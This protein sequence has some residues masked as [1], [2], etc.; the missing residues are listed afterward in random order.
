MSVGVV[1]A[2]PVVLEEVFES[3]AETAAVPRVEA[4]CG[5]TTAPDS[6]VEGQPASQ[7]GPTEYAAIDSTLRHINS[8]TSLRSKVVQSWTWSASFHLQRQ[9]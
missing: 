4:R 1:V 6:E 9:S 7:D 2:V 5:K 8:V 3:G